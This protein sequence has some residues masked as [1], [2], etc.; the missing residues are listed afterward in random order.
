ML[1]AIDQTSATL[2]AH[3]LVTDILKTVINA[4]I[5]IVV[6]HVLGTDGVEVQFLLGAPGPFSSLVER[7]PDTQEVTGA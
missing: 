7:L 5:V 4:P 1:T 6:A 2:V 3:T